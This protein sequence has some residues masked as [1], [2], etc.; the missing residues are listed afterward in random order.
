M[1]DL[2]SNNSSSC[3]TIKCAVYKISVM[4][5]YNHLQKY[6]IHNGGMNIILNLLKSSKVYITI[7][8]FV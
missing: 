5:E 2:I 7:N 4:L 8:C 6:F 1:I 3:Q